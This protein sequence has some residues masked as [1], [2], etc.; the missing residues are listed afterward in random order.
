VTDPA[1]VPGGRVATEGAASHRGGA[2]VPESAAVHVG[3]VAAKGIVCQRQ[4]AQRVVVD[5]APV[6]GRVAAE[7]ATG[8]RQG[9]AVLN[10]AAERPGAELD[11]QAAER[12]RRTAVD[13]EDLPGVGAAE[14]DERG[15]GPLD[16]RGGA[17]GQGERAAG[18]RDRLAG[19]EDG[20]V[21]GDS[22]G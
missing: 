7:G 20:R 2:V 1:A 8:P 6:R 12:R 4:C 16:G 17:V 22:V 19:G 18:E 15:P 3:R 14:G 13:E 21:E 10:R 5:A 11:A 9:T